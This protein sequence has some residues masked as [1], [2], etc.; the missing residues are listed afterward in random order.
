MLKLSGK[1]KIFR[2]YKRNLIR[3]IDKTKLNYA[4]GDN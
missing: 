1:F 4:N 3:K 2:K